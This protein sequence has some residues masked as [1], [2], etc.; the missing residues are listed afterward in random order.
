MHVEE[1]DMP[2]DPLHHC[3]LG[4]ELQ[5]AVQGYQNKTLMVLKAIKSK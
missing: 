1:Q 5:A 2:L 3:M 4:V